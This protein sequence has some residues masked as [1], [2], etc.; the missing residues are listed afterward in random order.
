MGGGQSFGGGFSGSS[1]SSS[2]GSDGAGILVEIVFRILIEICF[3]EP[4]I[5]IPLL[6]VVIVIYVWLQNSGNNLTV[7]NFNQ[8]SYPTRPPSGMKRDKAIED[9]KRQDPNFSNVLFADFARLLYTRYH[10]A[11]ATN[12]KEPS[13]LRPFIAKPLY[14][15]MMEC[16]LSSHESA[17]ASIKD[18]IIGAATIEDI[19]VDG[20]GRQMIDVRFVANYTKV[21]SDNK[22]IPLYIEETVTFSREANVLSPGPDKMRSFHCP[23]CGSPVQCDIEGV[24]A[25]CGSPPEPGK[26]QW[27]MRTLRNLRCEGRDIIESET[28]EARAT[29]PCLPLVGQISRDG[30][31]RELVTRDTSFN[32]NEFKDLVTHSFKKLQN[33]WS[34]LEWESTRELQTLGLYQQNLFW[35]DRYRR[36]G[37]RNPLDDVKVIE[38]IPAK[39]EHD[40]FYDSIT[41]RITASGKDYV[42]DSNNKVIA[43]NKVVPVEFRE[44]WTFIKSHKK[45]GPG[46]SLS[47]DDTP[48]PKVQCPN[49]SATIDQAASIEC[50]FCGSPLQSDEFNWTLAF[51]SQEGAYLG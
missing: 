22:E 14:D 44:Y 17:P 49:C 3:H 11:S 43:G 12:F 45:Q 1:S 16:H 28:P 19:K 37:Q 26:M 40:A 38:I 5:G 13:A 42:V 8:S 34:T 48:S 6:I 2:G 51:V 7:N 41:V 32:L 18:F 33:A 31:L 47:D 46:S 4:I 29:R 21:T 9:I 23:K 25:N 15:Q 39:I 27:Q 10:Q 24:C 20:M 36:Q 50:P 30:K 35:I